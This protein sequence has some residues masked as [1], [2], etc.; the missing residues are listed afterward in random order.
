MLVNNRRRGK[1]GMGVALGV[2]EDYSLSKTFAAEQANTPPMVC[3]V[4]CMVC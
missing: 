1:R 2:I 4:S 3:F